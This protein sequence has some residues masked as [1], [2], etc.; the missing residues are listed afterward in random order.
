MTD[1]RTKIVLEGARETQ[2]AIRGLRKE[3]ADTEAA[4]VRGST[5]RGAAATK[6]ASD[7]KKAADTT[8]S[9][10]EAVE[11][12]KQEAR[13]KTVREHEQGI[14]REVQAERDGARSRLETIKSFATSA[15]AVYQS[16]SQRASTLSGAFGGRGREAMLTENMNLQMQM[17][18]ISRDIGVSRRDVQSEITAAA[19]ASGIDPSQIAAGLA[20][21]GDIGGGAAATAVLRNASAIGRHATAIGTDF[22]TVAAPLAQALRSG[23]AEDQIGAF[24][25]Q[26]TGIVTSQNVSPEALSGRLGNAFA[27]YG[28][29]TGATG[30]DA[31]LG[32]MRLQGTLG[33]AF[34]GERAVNT[35]YERVMGMLQDQGF[36]RRL[37]GVAGTTGTQGGHVGGLLADPLQTL[38]AMASSGNLATNQQFARLAGSAEGGASLA[39]LVNAMRRNGG[40]MQDVLGATGAAG[41]DYTNGVMQD[42]QGIAGFGNQANQMSNFLEN[43]QQFANYA[44]AMADGVDTLNSKFPGAV[45]GLDNMS[46]AIEKVTQALGFMGMAGGGAVVAGGAGGSAAALG[47]SGATAGVGTA[48]GGGT[49]LGVGAGVVGGALMVNEIVQRGQRNAAAEEQFYAMG[50]EAGRAERAAAAT[51]AP[52]TLGFF[53]PGAGTIQAT[54]GGASGRP[55][56][57]ALDRASVDTLAT[58]IG[59]RIGTETRR[60]TPERR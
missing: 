6:A 41:A 20:S 30:G 17:S 8:K 38:Q 34:G 37:Q 22:G 9:A 46:S 55:V 16:V 18:R 50:G 23:M 51:N 53:S 43:G 1:I 59:A 44:D 35:E 14:R 19:R 13:K 5:S 2:Q 4:S 54:G 28:T 48:L 29:A 25:N 15:I 45:E 47:G 56:T 36:Q 7:E 60:G 11:K 52:R 10:V 21:A 3:I 12:A 57:V 24:L 40:A 27:G 32:A 39:T 33:A 49:A 26:Y 31:V 58:N 42:M